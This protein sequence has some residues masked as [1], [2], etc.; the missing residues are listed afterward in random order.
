LTAHHASRQEILQAL[1]QIGSM[2]TTDDTLLLYVGGA[3]GVDNGRLNWYVTDTTKELPWFTGI[4]HDDLV[5]FLKTLPVNHIV[6]L[7][8][9]N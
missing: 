5:Q 2:I 6:V 9:K 3:N 8:E 4:F 7:G 1:V